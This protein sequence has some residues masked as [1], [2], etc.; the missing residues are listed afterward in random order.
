M[1]AQSGMHTS[2]Y[3]Q[4]PEVV[5][6]ECRPSQSS[7]CV[8]FLDLILH[9]RLLGRV[10]LESTFQRVRIHFQRN[11]LVAATI[12]ESAHVKLGEAR[13]AKL[14]ILLY[15]DEFVKQETVVERFMGDHD[16]AERDRSHSRLVILNPKPLS[17]G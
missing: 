17:I 9:R 7:F 11:R 16:I 4:P 5:P 13:N 2:H 10:R 8:P 1:L 14:P 3:G 15:M 12:Q 6:S